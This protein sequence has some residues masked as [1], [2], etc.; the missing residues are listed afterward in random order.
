MDAGIFY[1]LIEEV[2]NAKINLLRSNSMRK[3]IF[4]DKA[5]LGKKSL[6]DW[7]KRIV[8]A[9]KLRILIVPKELKFIQI[10]ALQ[11]V[12]IIVIKFTD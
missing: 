12:F 4:K 1:K 8:S 10:K 2:K 7:D 6:F 3:M 9:S 11:T 5:K